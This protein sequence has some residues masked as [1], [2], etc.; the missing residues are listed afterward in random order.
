MKYEWNLDATD[1]YAV[2]LTSG[3]YLILGNIYL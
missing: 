3:E 1:F 2:L